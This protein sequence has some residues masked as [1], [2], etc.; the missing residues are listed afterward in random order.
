MSV[1]V[2]HLEALK[3]E[4]SAVVLIMDLE[5]LKHAFVIPHGKV[6]AIGREVATE[7]WVSQLNR[8]D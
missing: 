6:L 2:E 3:L 4:E 1:E 8:V 7:A 5:D